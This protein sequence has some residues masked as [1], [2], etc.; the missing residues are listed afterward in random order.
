[1]AIMDSANIELTF[2][3]RV[4]VVMILA[5]ITDLLKKSVGMCVLA[6]KNPYIIMDDDIYTSSI[7]Q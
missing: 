2:N 5:S 1:M 4:S 3:G 7:C 6:I